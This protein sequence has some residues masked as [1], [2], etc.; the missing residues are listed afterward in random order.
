MIEQL[1]ARVFQARDMAHR[2]HWRTKSY[3]VHMAL[4]SFYD[5]VVGAIV[6]IIE[7]YQGEFGLIPAFGFTMP[8]AFKGDI[9]PYLKK[10]VEWII[11]NR[12][13]VAK[14]STAVQNLIDTLLE[15]YHTTIYK[16]E[17]LS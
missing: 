8:A 17:N 14:G 11:D 4:G 7:C 16:L 13:D 10:E 5:D 2:E 15:E 1:A 3:A 6:S 12:E 9:I